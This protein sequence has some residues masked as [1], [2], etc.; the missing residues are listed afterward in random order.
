M[1]PGEYSAT[2]TAGE[3]SGT[4]SFQVEKDPRS[5]ATDAEIE[6]W[7][8]R[9]TEVTGL[10]NE[11]LDELAGV[12]RAKSQIAALVER[13]PGNAELKVAGNAA[14]NKLT[15]W[16]AGLIQPLHQTYED[17]DAWETMLVGQL[18]YLMDVIDGTGAPVTGGALLR[19]EDLKDQWAELQTELQAIRTDYIDVINVWMSENNIPHV[20]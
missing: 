20:N 11:M 19:L 16:D 9:L 1:K 2:I 8:G 12:R 14:I 15:A 5:T 6:F 10:L 3:L 17:E 4:V 7:S 18:R 13:Y